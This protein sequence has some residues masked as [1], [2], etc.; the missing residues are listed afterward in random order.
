MKILVVISLAIAGCAAKPPTPAPTPATTPPTCPFSPAAGKLEMKQYFLVLLRRGPAWTPESTEATKKVFE[1]HMA[2][3]QAMAKTG[4]L[5][6]A[7]PIDAPPTDAAAIAGIFVF[8]VPARA[9]V[10]ALIANDPAISIKRLV[11]EI[12][13][14]F[15]P[16]GLTYPG[17]SGVLGK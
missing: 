6:L 11:P 4:K 12:L 10:E 1:G 14:W 5:V 8:D 9:D 16:A 15:G 3:I 13:P 17:Q 7:G 2:N